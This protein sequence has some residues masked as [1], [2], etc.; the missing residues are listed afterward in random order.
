M[1]QISP[2]FWKRLRY[3]LSRVLGT[4]LQK[5]KGIY[6]VQINGKR[7]KRMTYC[8]SFQTSMLEQHLHCF[9]DTPYF[10]SIATRYEHELWLT[11]VEGKI[12]EK[13]DESF[14]LKFVDF[15]ATLYAKGPKLLETKETMFPQQLHQ[16][17]KFLGQVGV[18]SAEEE[19]ALDL[20]A[21]QLVPQHVWVGYD[22]TD[23]V[24]KNFVLATPG[25][26]LCAVDVEGLAHHQLIGMGLGKAFALWGKEHQDHILTQLLKRNVPDFVSYFPFIELSFLAKWTKRSFFEHKWKFVNA[27]VFEKFHNVQ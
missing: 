25:L 11:F 3:F 8:D 1:K 6:F 26:Q 20:C 21:Q 13:V 10:P 22:F 17:L 23:P 5:A 24:L 18:L 19:S 7:F 4:R 12:V 16:D 2:F 9:V 15:Y 27:K 14:L